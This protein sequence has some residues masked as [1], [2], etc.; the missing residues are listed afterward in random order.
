MAHENI[1]GR[2]TGL[3]DPKH[4]FQSVVVMASDC[5]GQPAEEAVQAI[6]SVTHNQKH[7]SNA[8]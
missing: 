6:V 4:L 5:Y 7:E 3:D 1:I 8:P 2:Y